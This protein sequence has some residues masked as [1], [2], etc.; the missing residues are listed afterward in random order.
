MSL[1]APLY[2][3]EELQPRMESA[4][5]ELGFRDAKVSPPKFSVLRHS[6]DTEE[7]DVVIRVEPGSRSF[8]GEIRFENEQ[9]FPSDR[10][11]SLFPMQEGDP[12]NPTAVGVGLEGLRKLYATEGYAEF[13]AVPQLVC[14]EAQHRIDL[15]ISL[16]AGQQYSFGRLF[17]EGT[18][19][20]AG[21]AKELWHAWQAVE[22][23]HYNPSL[24]NRWLLANFS[25]PSAAADPQRI[26][27]S[28]HSESRTVDI[29]LLLP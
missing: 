3:E 2:A 4:Y 9:Q 24:L 10:L 20:H 13:V 21:A 15:V 6:K 12:F 1:F 25:D 26:V 8:L 17:L 5:K 11:R 7:V 22:G 16:D 19:Q 29:K 18:E 28:S 27:T 14:D 23:Q